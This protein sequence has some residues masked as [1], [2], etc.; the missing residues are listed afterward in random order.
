MSPAQRLDQLTGL[1][2]HL[3]QRVLAAIG[4][5]R[6]LAPLVRGD[7]ARQKPAVGVT[8]ASKTT[9][10]SCNDDSRGRTR[11]KSPTAF[12]DANKPSSVGALS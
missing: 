6:D 10:A 5:N 8:H 9:I 1:T 12:R 2:I 3:E 7:G 11:K 4:I